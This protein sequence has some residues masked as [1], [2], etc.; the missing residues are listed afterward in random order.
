MLGPDE[1]P[2]ADDSGAD[3]ADERDL[4]DLKEAFERTPYATRTPFRT[5]APIQ[6]TLA[7]RVIRGRI[8]AVYKEGDGSSARYEIVDWKTGREATADPLQLAVYRV[9]WAEQLGIPLEAVRAAFVYVRTG[10]TVRP[11][12]LPGRAELTAI[13]LGQSPRSGPQD[14]PPPPAG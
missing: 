7:G 4:A 13:L 8:D 14:E 6:L 12:R 5:E 9:A 3:I 11:A 10:E 2:G 1:L